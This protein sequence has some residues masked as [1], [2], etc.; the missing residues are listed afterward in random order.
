MYIGHGQQ[1]C[2]ERKKEKEVMAEVELHLYV[3]T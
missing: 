3:Q 2:G 1:Y